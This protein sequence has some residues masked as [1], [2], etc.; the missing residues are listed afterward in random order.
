MLFL[1]QDKYFFINR[2][3]KKEYKNKQNKF[4]FNDINK[5]LVEKIR[6]LDKSVKIIIIDKTFCVKTVTFKRFYV[7]NHV[8]KSGENPLR[9][10]QKIATSPF[11]DITSLY[12]QKNKGVVT[13]GLGKKYL[14]E[15]KKHKYPSTHL[16]SIAILCKALGFSKIEG[17]L[18]NFF[19]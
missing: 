5:D 16:V 14:D 7:N 18:I 12:L 1:D 19:E 3:L 15:R 6:S 11:F 2:E 10:N 13:T 17:Q 4:V 9:G 8:N